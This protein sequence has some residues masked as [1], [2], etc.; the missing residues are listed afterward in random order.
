MSL[1]NVISLAGGLALFLYG[2]SAMGGGLEKLAGSK[3]EKILE[4]LTGNIFLAVLVGA[5]ITGVIQSS[6]A[7]TVIIV[8]L[9]N[10]RIMKLKQAVGLIMG[11]NIGTTITSQIIRLGD[12]DEGSIFLILFKPA[13]LAPLIAFIGIILF[14]FSKKSKNNNIGQIML[15]F[16]VLFSGM[17]AMEAA[18]R[19][20]RELEAFT[21]LFSAFSNP[22]LGI[23]VG[24]VVTAI[25]Q[26]SSASVGILQA[27]S[28]TG[29]ITYSS[30]IPI[31]L[32]QNIGTCITPIISSIGASK[33]AKRAAMIHLYFNIIGTAVFIAVIYLLQGLGWFPFW[34]DTI[35]RGGIANFHLIFNLL[36]TLLFIPF[37]GLL[38]KLAELTISKKGDSEQTTEISVLDERFLHTPSGFLR[39]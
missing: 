10:A 9:V 34:M 17:L 14:M 35:D 7:M 37:A 18:V 31:I 3:L 30:A 33:N 6:S 19:P 8:G 20:L 39:V 12:I 36:T 15:G 21:G 16:G 25:I 32:G 23:L 2:M 4:R 22:L 1:V 11:A 24:A 28:S 27:L 26:S 13:T 29:V 38:I 5:L